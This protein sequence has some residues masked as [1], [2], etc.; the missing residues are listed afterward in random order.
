MTDKRPPII[1]LAIA[2]MFVVTLAYLVA[3]SFAPRKVA[4]FE[5]SVTSG[6]S[7]RGSGQIDTLTVDARLEGTWRY[8]DLERRLALPGA[9]TAGWDLA[10]MRHRHDPSVPKT[11]ARPRPNRCDASTGVRAPSAVTASASTTAPGFGAPRIWYVESS[12]SFSQDSRLASSASASC[13][14]SQ[15]RSVS[16]NLT[17]FLWKDAPPLRFTS[18]GS[19][20]AIAE[21]W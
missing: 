14:R 10:F 9:D 17:G 8:A 6:D 1:I 5:P 20:S 13:S 11:M 3:A 16:W 15:H 18:T 7:A 4:T 19:R 2:G 12:G 21:V